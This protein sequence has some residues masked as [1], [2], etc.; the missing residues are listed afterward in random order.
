MTLKPKNPAKGSPAPV[1]LLKDYPDL[2][3]LKGSNLQRLQF[4]KDAAKLAAD[5]MAFEEIKRKAREKDIAK[6]EALTAE[7]NKASDVLA[8]ER[9]AKGRATRMKTVTKKSAATAAKILA[10]KTVIDPLEIELDAKATPLD[11]MVEAMRVAYKRGGAI[12]AFPFAKECAP[13]MHA[14]IASIELKP[15]G[16]QGATIT[17][18][19]RE[20][21]PPPVSVDDLIGGE[22]VPA[23]IY[24][25]FSGDVTDVNP[26]E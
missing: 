3:I 15:P 1:D 18:I 19:V 14:R 12:Y 8:K 23:R 24:P 9:T 16:S 6:I 13:Y 26:N 10:G 2:R 11:V 4:S 5:R 21:L 22:P 25:P 20:I 17:R 7:L